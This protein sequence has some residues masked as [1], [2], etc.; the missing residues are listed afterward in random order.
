[1]ELPNLNSTYD[2]LQELLKRI[3]I[4]RDKILF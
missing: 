2:E 3:N 4:Q 1:M